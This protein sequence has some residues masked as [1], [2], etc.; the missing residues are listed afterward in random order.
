MNF[1]FCYY[2]LKIKTNKK[3]FFRAK[4]LQMF[5]YFTTQIIGIIIIIII[6]KA[7]SVIV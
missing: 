3:T 1:D 5:F 7:N 2:K 4:I 6:I